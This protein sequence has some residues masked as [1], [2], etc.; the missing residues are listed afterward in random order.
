[1]GFKNLTK[2]VTC[3]EF[4]VVWQLVPKPGSWCSEGFHSVHCC[5]AFLYLQKCIGL[6]SEYSHGIYFSIISDQ[7]LFYTLDVRNWIL[8][9]DLKRTGSQCSWNKTGDICLLFR[10]HVT[11][12]AA[13]FRERGILYNNALHCH[14]PVEKGL[15]LKS[16]IFQ[17][18]SY[19][20]YLI[21][22]WFTYIIH[23]LLHS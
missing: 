14:S 12:R 11:R 4:N 21:I 2:Y 5:M 8:Y 18:N 3:C 23:L 10:V 22:T 9:S 20:S 7:I 15:G 6:R 19:I 13:Q 1:M 17:N 16:C